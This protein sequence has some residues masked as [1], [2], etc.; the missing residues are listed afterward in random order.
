ME[1]GLK[2]IITIFLF[3]NLF[4]N[5]VDNILKTL[6]KNSATYTLNVTLATKI[7][8]I[9]YKTIDFNTKKI[10]T[11]TDFV[12]Y[13]FELV[14][15]K[16]Q[17]KSIPKKIDELQKKLNLLQNSTN[18][19]DKLQ[20]IY[21]TKLI[22]NMNLKLNEIDNNF[23]SWENL[24]YQTMN[25]IDFNVKIA[26][27][28]IKK[29]NIKLIQKKEEFEK[30]NINLQRWELINN[31]TNISTT[32]QYIKTNLKI[33]NRIYQNILKNK[34][35]I[36]FYKLKHKNKEVFTEDNELVDLA[37]HIDKKLSLSLSYV[38]SDF[39]KLKFGNTVLIYKTKDEIKLTFIKIWD[40]LN[41]PLFSVSGRVITPINFFIFILVLIIGVLIGKYY[42][43]LIFTIKYNYN[44]SHASATLLSNIGY[45]IIIVISFLIALKIV[46]LDLSS[47]AI[48]AG[49]LSVGIGFGLQNIVSNSVSGIIMM[50]EKTIKV[51]DYIQIDSDT[52]GEVL[53]I[54]LRS[55]VI[56]TNDNI[57]L[58]I[59]NQSFIQNNVINWTLGDDE[60]RF[61][62]P[63]GVAYG[64]DIDEVEKV[65]IKALE[66]SDLPYIR[67]ISSNLKK[68]TKIDYTPRV[69]FEEMADS[70]LN[71]ELFVWVKGE[72]ARRP[73]RT[74][75]EFLKL[76]YSALNKAGI[77]IPFPQQDLHIVDSIPL[78]L[79]LK[80]D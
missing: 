34:L 40:I 44:I 11:D 12:N 35:I 68:Y 3:V 73:R 27:N 32:M 66:N 10:K 77:T 16:Q 14:S 19:T 21:Y 80:K 22:K 64:N 7:K 53:D 2:F 50:F 28:N 67:P 48:I 78:E 70:S 57:N 17:L 51:G 23:N 58:I 69:I 39:E 49:A 20:S 61:R 6:S 45:Y 71:F 37:N 79:K 29:L 56:K 15:L 1:Y 60:V 31:K 54:S 65:I 18:P 36:W 46:G 52:R 38:L 5:E 72:Y 75:S 9:K 74:K 8:D 30:L 59:P 55:T 33:Q 43:K 76:I 42:K 13:F 25:N 62:I 4:G 24:L 63:F 26:K 47:L 41:Y